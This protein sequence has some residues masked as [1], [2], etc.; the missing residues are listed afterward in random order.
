LYS[1][2]FFYRRG[3]CYQPLPAGVVRGTYTFVALEEN[4][5]AALVTRSEVVARLV[6]LYSGYDIR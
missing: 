4:D 3:T 1:Q 6:E 2:V 5:A